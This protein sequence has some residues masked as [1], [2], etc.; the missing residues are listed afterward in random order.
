MSP[1]DQCKYRKTCEYLKEFSKN[2]NGANR[3]V[4]RQG[5]DDYEKNLRSKSRETVDEKNS[6]TRIE[7]KICIRQ[8]PKEILHSLFFL[9]EMCTVH[10]MLFFIIL[11]I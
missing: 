2:L 8:V 9:L 6:Y 10:V 7:P 1:P 4:R 11:N 5:G 3:I